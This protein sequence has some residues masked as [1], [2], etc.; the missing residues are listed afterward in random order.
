MVLESAKKSEEDSKLSEA[1]QE[2][3]IQLKVY[4]EQLENQFK[5]QTDIIDALKERIIKVVY[6]WCYLGQ[7]HF[8][9]RTL[10][11]FVNKLSDLDDIDEV[12]TELGHFAQNQD[13]DTIK[14][15]KNI[16]HIVTVSGSKTSS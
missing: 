4:N 2:D 7:E 3:L 13:K 9:Q 12:Q 15:L 10:A 8:Q 1:L 5:A 14:F 11:D 16:A 6:S